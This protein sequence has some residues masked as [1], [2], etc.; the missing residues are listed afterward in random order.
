M[1][2]DRIFYNGG[3]RIMKLVESVQQAFQNMTNPSPH[4]LR[5]VIGRLLLTSETVSPYLAEPSFLPYGRTVMFQS[6]SVEVILIHL[7][8]GSQTWIHDHGASV[9]CAYIVEGQ[10]TNTLFRPGPEGY[11]YECGESC[12]TEGQFMYAPQGQIHQM[13][14]KGSDRMVS[15]HVYT[16]KLSGMKKYSTYEQVLDFVI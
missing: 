4:E 5:A 10:L 7:P 1:E 15:L 3:V 8:S 14:N 6:D 2:S 13:S 16:P 12:V 11:V 9:G